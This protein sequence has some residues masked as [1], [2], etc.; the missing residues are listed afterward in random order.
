MYPEL[1]LLKGT[2]LSSTDPPYAEVW[3]ELIA[4]LLNMQQSQA[5]IHMFVCSVYCF[6]SFHLFAE[7]S[8]PVLF[9]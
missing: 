1:G 5:H 7:P 9:T 6:Q 2:D 3:Q 4:E 8:F